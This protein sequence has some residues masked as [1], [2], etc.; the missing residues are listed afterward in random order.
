MNT[1]SFK[2]AVL[3]VS[4]REI[5]LIWLALKNYKETVVPG[6][7]CYDPNSKVDLKMAEIYG[8]SIWQLN[9]ECIDNMQHEIQLMMDVLEDA[10]KYYPFIESPSEMM[11][12]AK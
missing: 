9:L 3:E 2:S 1:V 4:T 11:K 6:Y 5:N 12:G 10:E 8:K 7:R